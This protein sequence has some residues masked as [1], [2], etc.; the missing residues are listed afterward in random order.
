[1]TTEYPTLRIFDILPGVVVTPMMGEA[2]RPLA[3]DHPDL[4]GMVSLW[5]AQP[6]AD[7]LSGQ[8]VSV[9]WDLETMEAHAEEIS[10]K[11]LLRLQYLPILPVAGGSGI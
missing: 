3:K 6:R 4:L 2:Y 11:N 5:L 8:L 10:E 7:F 9:N 1:V